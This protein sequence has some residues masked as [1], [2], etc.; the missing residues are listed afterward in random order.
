MVT[1][2]SSLAHNVLVWARG[3]LTAS[4]PKLALAARYVQDDG[5]GS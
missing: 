5:A 3:W 1:L 4:A 2:L